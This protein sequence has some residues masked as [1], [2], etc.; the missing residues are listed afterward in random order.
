MVRIPQLKDIETAIKVYYSRVDLSNSD[1][2][3]LFGNLS[4]ATIAKLKKSVKEKMIEENIPVG[5]TNRVRTDL[6]FRAWGLEIKDLEKRLEKLKKL[7]L[8]N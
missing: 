8:I 1:I 6:A 3:E 5:D 2:K 7:N 4:S